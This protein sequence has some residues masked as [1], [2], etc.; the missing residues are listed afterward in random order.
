MNDCARARGLLDI[1]CACLS[2]MIA[3]H[4]ETERHTMHDGNVHSNDDY[5]FL[6]NI[7]MRTS[8]KNSDFCLFLLSHFSSQKQRK[9]ETLV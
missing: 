9:V 8:R 6:N 3:I 2:V 1:Q 5:V 7:P 4:R